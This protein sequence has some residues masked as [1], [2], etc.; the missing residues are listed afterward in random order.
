MHKI[1]AFFLFVGLSAC[2]A[3]SIGRKQSAGARGRL[4]CDQ[5]PASGVLVKMYDDDRGVDLDD[6]M[7]ETHTDSEG[8]FE[9]SGTSHEFTSIDPKINPCQRKFSIMIPDSYI[10]S[11]DRPSRFYDAG[12]WSTEEHERWN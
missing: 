2:S 7:G 6:F 5:K 11:G 4:M 3:V 10:A 9:F 8:Y 1:S 12:E